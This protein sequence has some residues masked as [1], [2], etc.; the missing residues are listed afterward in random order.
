MELSSL[1]VL[2]VFMMRWRVIRMQ[3]NFM[4]YLVDQTNFLI[5]NATYIIDDTYNFLPS[6][7]CKHVE[8][9]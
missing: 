4:E 5:N 6:Y 1:F 2:L 8:I 9:E 3:A 7:D